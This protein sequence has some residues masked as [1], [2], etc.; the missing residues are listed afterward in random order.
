MCKHG[1]DNLADACF[2]KATFDF[3]AEGSVPKLIGM[4][5]LESAGDHTTADNSFQYRF[6]LYGRHW[7]DPSAKV[8]FD[9][10]AGDFCKGREAGSY[11]WND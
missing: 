10:P 11:I 5:D 2:L 9:G 4:G 6:S 1:A 8:T 7:I 3:H